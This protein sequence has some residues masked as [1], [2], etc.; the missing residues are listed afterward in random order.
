MCYYAGSHFRRACI[1]P[2]SD[3]IIVIV[4]AWAGLKAGSQCDASTVGCHEASQEKAS[5]SLVNVYS[6]SHIFDILIGL[7]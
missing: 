7:G 1:R 6:R 5:F 2:C 4:G 3:E